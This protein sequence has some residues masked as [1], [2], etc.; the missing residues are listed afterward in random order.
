MVTT[1]RGGVHEG[2]IPVGGPSDC[3]LDPEESQGHSGFPSQQSASLKEQ[4]QVGWGG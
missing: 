4:K 3:V 1:W 2:L